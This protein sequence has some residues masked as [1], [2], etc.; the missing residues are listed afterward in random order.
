MFE[1]L[2]FGKFD[3]IELGQSKEWILRNFTDPDDFNIDTFLKPTISIWQYGKFEFHFS[4][5]QLYMIF[6]DHFQ[7]NYK[8][9]QFNAGESIA[10]QPWIFE[11]PAQLTLNF[12][13]QIFVTENI[14]FEKITT[15]HNIM[16]KTQG[17]VRLY[18]ADDYDQTG[19][20]IGKDPNQ[21]MLHAFGLTN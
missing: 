14:D 20:L 9:E 16:I 3:F 10:V 8:G 1:F 19:E 11:N 5:N 13:M 4:K 17:G 2:K 7:S 12:V 15:P 18:F 21:F 6:S